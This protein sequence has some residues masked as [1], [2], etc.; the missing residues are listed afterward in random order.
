ML[1]VALTALLVAIEARRRYGRRGAWFAGLLFVFALV[2][3]A[4]QDGQA[5]NFEIFM[6]PA[7][8]AAVLLARRGRARRPRASRSRSRRW[9]SRRARP[10]LLPVLYLAWR[11][12]GRRGV[13]DALGGFAM[14]L[15]LVAAALGAG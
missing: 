14:P 13:T 7:M 1:A 11:A 15:A 10:T 12:R 3:F 9:R 8:T 6:L 5:A 2:A 4:P